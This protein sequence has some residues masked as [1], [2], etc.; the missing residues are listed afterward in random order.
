[1][2][3]PADMPRKRPEHSF[4]PPLEKRKPDLP[5]PKAVPQWHCRKKRHAT[6]ADADRALGEVWQTVTGRRLEAHSYQCRRHGDRVV[7][8]LTKQ[9]P[10]GRT[11]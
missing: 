2:I 8:H 3:S 1:M 5:V 7:W 11:A 4:R 6:Q 10:E 9:D